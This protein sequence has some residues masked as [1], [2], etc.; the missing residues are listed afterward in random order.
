M[1]RGLDHPPILSE[2]RVAEQALSRLG[3]DSLERT[4]LQSAGGSD[5]D[6]DH[7]HEA[8]SIGRKNFASTGIVIPALMMVRVSP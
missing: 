5:V 3:D 2:L 4:H 7:L 8:K 6:W 1:G